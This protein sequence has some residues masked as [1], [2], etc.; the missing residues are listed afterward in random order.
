MRSIALAAA[1][2]GTLAA[3]VADVAARVRAADLQDYSESGEA[4]TFTDLA[5]GVVEIRVDRPGD[6]EISFAVDGAIGERVWFR[7]PDPPPGLEP[8]YSYGDFEWVRIDDVEPEGANGL[9]LSHRLRRE[10][11]VIRLRPRAEIPRGPL[12]PP[13]YTWPMWQ[14]Y[15]ATLTGAP[16]LTWSVV[17]SSFQGRELYKIVVEDTGSDPPGPAWADSS[18]KHVLIL[19]R[20]HGDETMTNYILEGFIDYLIGRRPAQPPPDLFDRV[21]FVFYPLVNPDGAVAGQRYNAQG[22]DLNRQWLSEGCSPTQ[23]HEIHIIQCDFEAD[24]RRKVFRM[25]VDFHGWWSDPDGGYRFALN[26]PPGNAPANYWQN[27][28]GWFRLLESMDRWRLYS[29]WNQNGGTDGMVRL[30]LLQRYGLDMHTPETNEYTP[31]TVASLRTEGEIYAKAIAAYLLERDFTDAA[32]A[33][34]PAYGVGDEIYATVRDHDENIS[35]ATAETIEAVVISPATGDREPMTLLETGSDTG[36]FRNTAGLPSSSSSPMVGN[37]VIETLV[38]ATLE[39]IYFDDDF[40]YD[41]SGDTAIVGA[42]E[43]RASPRSQTGGRRDAPAGATSER[44]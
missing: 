36:V 10:H 22:L 26:A 33:V 20:Q 42:V 25:G 6:D 39:L 19:G 44:R 4:L 3:S 37:G 23:A 41:H 14:T 35:P 1:L 29:S 21:S 16:H 38:G 30:E 24:A 27:Q 8:S 32:G 9:V 13:T 18:K 5:P 7:L 15:M 17:G 34:Q 43:R 12:A 31:R 11:V 2:L 28:D 40:P